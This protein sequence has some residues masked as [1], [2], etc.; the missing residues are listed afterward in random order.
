MI[1]DGFIIHSHNLQFHKPAILKKSIVRQEKY[2]ISVTIK[3]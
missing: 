2:Q 3:M 1:L